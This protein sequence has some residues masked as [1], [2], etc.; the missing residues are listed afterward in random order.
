MPAYLFG[1]AHMDEE[2]TVIP[3]SDDAEAEAVM[4]DYIHVMTVTQLNGYIKSLL[5]LSEGLKDV[6][7]SGEISNLKSN[8]Q[9][10][11]LYFTLKDDGGVLNSVMFKGYASKLKFI[12]ENGMKATVYG[13]V[14]LYPKSGALS[15]ACYAMEPLGIG[16]LYLAFEQLK[17]RL[18]AEGL[19]REDRRKKIPI[20]PKKIG[21]ITSP[22][23]AA[24]CDMVDITGRRFPCAA[25]QV[26]PA[27]VQGDGAEDSL[28][29]GLDW[30]N[31]RTGS[32]RCD[33]IIIGRGGGSMEDLWAFNSEK[34]A[35]QIANSKI[36]VISA[37]GHESDFTI[38]DF[39]ADR[40][41]PTPSAAAELAVPDSSELR[42]RLV[43]N[44]RYLNTLIRKTIEMRRQRLSLAASTP[45]ILSPERRLND[46]RSELSVIKDRLNT[47][48]GKQISQKN[49]EYSEYLAK[50]EALS[51]L[52]VLSRGYALTF[53]KE[54]HVVRSISSISRGDRLRIRLSDGE[55]GVAVNEIICK[56]HE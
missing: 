55:L 15:F 27:L 45:V 29:A 32:E 10:G 5:D 52:A 42:T 2:L 40:R 9:T 47:A 43:N 54:G 18:G 3:A 44:Y 51:P 35:R 20:F 16:A 19:F 7:V 48:V 12:P 8:H 1:T 21:I 6:W 53:D 56:T 23:G 4:N 49:T 17:I 13:T 14:T 28:I 22:T 31:S 46:I 39:V 34:L 30:F 25:L 38:C 33:V 11:H 41:A 37:V 24:I 36:P 50:L 26:W